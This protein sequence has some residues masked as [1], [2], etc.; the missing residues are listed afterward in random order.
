MTQTPDGKE[1]PSLIAH[2]F[3]R[4]LS[5][6]VSEKAVTTNMMM[7]FAHTAERNTGSTYPI[8]EIT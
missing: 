2:Q 6:D 4:L 8:L 7:L 5:G 1:T 3:V